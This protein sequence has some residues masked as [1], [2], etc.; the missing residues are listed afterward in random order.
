[1]KAPEI[2]LHIT[3]LL[4]A[5]QIEPSEVKL[6]IE[7]LTPDAQRKAEYALAV[8]VQTDR[9]LPVNVIE[10]CREGRPW[11][12]YGLN[13]QTKPL[14]D[15]NKEYLPACMCPSCEAA[16]ANAYSA[17]GHTVRG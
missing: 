1:M 5:C 14:Q 13:L 12:M 10:T 8:A 2:I 15:R 11:T 7:F 9:S 17:A 16:R 4:Q 6:T 3:R